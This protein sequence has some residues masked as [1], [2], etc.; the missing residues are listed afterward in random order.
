M[1]Q[2]TLILIDL[3]KLVNII[4]EATGVVLSVIGVVAVL[5][6]HMSNRREVRLLCAIFGCLAVALC[7]NLC[8]L[9]AKGHEG[10]L[11]WWMVHVSNFLEFAFTYLDCMLVALLLFHKLEP[12]GRYPKL[13][14]FLWALFAFYLLLVVLS[15]RTGWIYYIDAA[16]VC[17]RG[18]WHWVG[19]AMGM[20]TLTTCMA[21]LV[22]HGSKLPPRMRW[23][24]WI[25][26]LVPF[27]ATGLQ[28][29]FYGI[30]IV[31]FAM[32]LGASVLLV[33]IIGDSVDMLVRQQRELA[34]MK[35]AL[36][37][38]QMRPHFLFNS[39][40]VIRDLC[41]HDPEQARVALD[42]FSRYLRCNLDSM[43]K[44]GNIPFNQELRH[45]QA[46]L[47]LEKLRFGERLNVVYKLQHLDFELPPLSVQP[48]VENAVKH[49]IFPKGEGGTLT[50]STWRDAEGSHVRVEDDGAGFDPLIDVNSVLDSNPATSIDSAGESQR[51]HVGIENVRNRLELAGSRLE[52]ESSQGSG[53]VATI[54][55]CE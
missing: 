31:L 41:R 43:G 45:I 46:Y 1:G 48:L 16:N 12:Y 8:G 4:V 52:L 40:A 5:V 30:Y 2:E 19:L 23:G 47:N 55:I 15:Q 27:V 49:G 29:P 35:A 9:L 51:R 22:R 38:S 54:T 33:V 50:I 42:D 26:M 17:H 25:F 44:T 28:I 13:K 7:A 37:M 34:E 10:T 24:F 14:A 11:A 18:P 39:L 32:V 36:A 53:T 21:L 20:V 3:V 6:S